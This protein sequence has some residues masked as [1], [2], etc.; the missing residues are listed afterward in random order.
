MDIKYYL[1]IFLR[2][3]W[4]IVL[5]TF[6]VSSFTYVK[7]LREPIMYTAQAR[8]LYEA[9]N[10][11]SNIL[12]QSGMMVPMQW[13][14]PVDTQIQLITTR[15]NVEE[16]VKRLGIRLTPD[17]VLSGLA[18]EVDRNTDIILLR[19]TGLK[20]ENS[21]KIVNEIGRVFVERD[22]AYHKETARETRHFIEEQ[23]MKTEKLLATAEDE[24]RTFREQNQTFSVAGLGSTY[25]SQLTSID[26]QLI[27]MDVD[28]QVVQA[29]LDE[30]RRHLEVTDPG[31][32]SRLEK[33]QADKTF[34]TLSS[35]LA[36]MESDVALKRSQYAADA[37][38]LKAAM[39][40]RDRLK[41]IVERHAATILGRTP[42]QRELQSAQTP[43][44]TR[45]MSQLIESQTSIAALAAKA[46]ALKGTRGTYEAKFK[47]IPTKDLQMNHLVRKQQAAEETY[48]VFF[49][50]MQDM[51]ITEAVNTGN[52]RLIEEAVQS[53]PSITPL[54]KTVGLAALLGLIFG[55]GIALLVEFLDDRIRRPEEA[56]NVLEL[57]ILGLLPWVEN[58]TT[59]SGRQRL[60]TLDD[61]RSPVTESYRALQTYTRL[62]DPDRSYQTFMLTSPGP[63]E[64][65]ST[66]LA[67][68]AVT[69]A[70]LGKRTLIVD[71]DLRAPSQHLNFDRPNLVGIYDVVYEACP[72]EEAIQPTDV[73]GLDILCTGPVPPDPVQTLHAE[74]FR[75][76]VERLKC[77]YDAIFFDSP[78][79]NLFTDAA[80]LGRTV[81][82]VLLV[83][84]VRST[85]RQGTLTAKELLNKAKVPLAGMVVKNMTSKNSR[86][87]NRYFERY[88]VDRLKHMADD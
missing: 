23:L 63:K 6:L 62:V 73:E 71:T 12:G 74:A 27:D 38:E 14:N 3:W 55:L 87:H 82:S 66:V 65:K 54:G 70:Q 21:V 35:E 57:P 9:N 46:G 81:D 24:L 15:P 51:R 5:S 37:P 20:P 45:Y 88:Y 26:T 67:N 29:R 2:R 58:R 16:V 83:V 1:G 84:D 59:V 80:V 18:A 13:N 85:T 31:V 56:Q 25:S 69:S 53:V 47:D 28:R 50:R 10:V 86:F 43:T 77:E 17:E 32:I 78:P 22:K 72:L 68:L 79:I 49:K 76:M 39:G 48:T 11:A 41:G 40:E 7:S 19:Y 4:L 64:G 8:L 36:R 42:D 61:P 33:L 60:V 44:E 52:V 75:K 30:A 34:G